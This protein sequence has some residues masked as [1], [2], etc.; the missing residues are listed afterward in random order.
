MRRALRDQ[1]GGD[2][3]RVPAKMS[4]FATLSLPADP[5]MTAP[6][7]SEVRVLVGHAS[8]H[9]GF[10]HFGMGAATAVKLR[11]RSWRSRPGVDDAV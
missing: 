1:G 5:A 3:D 6:D 11:V 4:R 10:L 7:G 2:G 9:L 8:G